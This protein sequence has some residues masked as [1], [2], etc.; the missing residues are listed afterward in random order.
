[1]EDSVDSMSDNEDENDTL[2]KQVVKLWSTLAEKG[3]KFSICVRIK[4]FKFS[5][6]SETPQAPQV[7]RRSPSYARRQERR[8]LLLKKKTGASSGR[9]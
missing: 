7:K 5:L 8:K 2:L 9:S 6:K 1:M 4:D 3:F